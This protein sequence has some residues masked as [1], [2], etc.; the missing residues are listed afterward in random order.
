MRVLLL[1][2]I[3][4]SL[5]SYSAFTCQEASPLTFNNGGLAENNEPRAD[6]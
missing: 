3:F 4:I 5:Q 1:R 6:H 2:F